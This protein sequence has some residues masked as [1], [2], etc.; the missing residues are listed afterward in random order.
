MSN[1]GYNRASR[2]AFAQV[3][4]GHIKE[5]KEPALAAAKMVAVAGVLRDRLTLAEVVAG[6]AL[7][8]HRLPDA[9]VELEAGCL[10]C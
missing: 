6:V 3:F 10:H 2:H 5:R 9:G 4:H 7:L 1:A 8:I